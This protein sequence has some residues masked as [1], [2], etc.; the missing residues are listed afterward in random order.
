MYSIL[1]GH[2]N[3]ITLFSISSEYGISYTLYSM[4]YAYYLLK[5]LFNQR[6][7]SYFVVMLI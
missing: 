1:K 4:V 5:E 2:Y 3:N 6:I 7:Q